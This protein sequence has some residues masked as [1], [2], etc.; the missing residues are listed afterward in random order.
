MALHLGNSEK[1][2]VYL[3]HTQYRLNIYSS[4]PIINGIKS[5]SSDGYILKDLDGM[6][7]TV[8]DMSATSAKSIQKLSE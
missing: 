4:D 8:L 3:N 1:L 5:L 6:Y 2:K 7:L